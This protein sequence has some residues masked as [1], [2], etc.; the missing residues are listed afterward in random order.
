MGPKQGSTCSDR[1]ASNVE[2]AV[3]SQFHTTYGLGR[4]WSLSAQ[5]RQYASKELCVL[6]IVSKLFRT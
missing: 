4:R 6:K 3:V 1:E 2:C 5:H